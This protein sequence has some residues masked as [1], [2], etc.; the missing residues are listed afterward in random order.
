MKR[1]VSLLALVVL[2]PIS[3]A[4]AGELDR[5]MA[6]VAVERAIRRGYAPVDFAINNAGDYYGGSGMVS[7]TVQ[8]AVIGAGV[9]A[10][11]GRG[12]KGALIGAGIG[13]GAAG[14]TTWLLNR[15]HSNRGHQPLDCRKKKN[16]ESCQAI[17]DQ[18]AVEEALANANMRI[19]N[20]TGLELELVDC[21]GS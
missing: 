15:R 20:R 1:F 11:I 18:Q 17:A 16:R 6:G 10:G 19:Y 7:N 14:L 13:G 2:I 12:T 4:E 9:G 8:G 21:D 3:Q 5:V